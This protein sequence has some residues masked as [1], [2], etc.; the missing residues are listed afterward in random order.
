MD[1][2]SFHYSYEPSPDEIDNDDDESG[3]VSVSFRGDHID[4]D[5]VARKFKAFLNAAGY[6][7]E[8]VGIDTGDGLFLAV[9]ED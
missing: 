5:D 3:T 4:L 6:P 1:T 8:N 2:I 9:D 7:V